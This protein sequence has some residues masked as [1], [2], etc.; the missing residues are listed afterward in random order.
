VEITYFITRQVAFGI[1]GNFL[2]DFAAKPTVKYFVEEAWVLTKKII[3]VSF[4]E[5][6]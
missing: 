2:I 5:N 4:S 3:Q 6:G 1:L